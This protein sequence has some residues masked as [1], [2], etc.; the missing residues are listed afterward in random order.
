MNPQNQQQQQTTGVSAIA[1]T[2]L[3]WREDFNNISYMG[4]FVIL[5][6]AGGALAFKVV[7]IFTG[8][9]TYGDRDDD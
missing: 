3:G 2:I 1:P 8:H 4:V 9:D 5:L 6:A 7:H